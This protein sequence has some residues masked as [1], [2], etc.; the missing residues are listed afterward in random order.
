MRWPRTVQGNEGFPT[1]MHSIG[2]PLASRPFREAVLVLL[3]AVAF[4]GVAQNGRAAEPV[5]EFPSVDPQRGRALFVSKGCVICH[6]INGV[7]GRAAPPL[8]ADNSASAVDIA[9]FAARMWQGAG[10]MVWLQTLELGYQIELT[11]DDIAN[12][13]GFVQDAGEQARFTEDT[14]PDYVRESLLSDLYRRPEDWLW[15]PESE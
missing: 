15:E 3:A 14:L 4:A 12:L 11:G 10:P 13:A 7:G 8:E 2:V 6:S 5:V 1:M 9:G